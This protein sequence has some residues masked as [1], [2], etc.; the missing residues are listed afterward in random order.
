VC[1]HLAASVVL[2]AHASHCLHVGYS[3]GCYSVAHGIY[4]VRGVN[5]GRGLHAVNSLQGV[6]HAVHFV[7][8]DVFGLRWQ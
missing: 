3:V 8:G 7:N 1:L 2:S 5:V 4:V 6:E